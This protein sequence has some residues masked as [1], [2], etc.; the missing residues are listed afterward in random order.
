M[1]TPAISGGQQFD[2]PIGK[3]DW[4]WFWK[5]FGGREEL[6]ILGWPVEW[7]EKAPAGSVGV[8]LDVYCVILT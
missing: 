2:V 8:H 1:L 6:G 4:C 7:V 3:T 5:G